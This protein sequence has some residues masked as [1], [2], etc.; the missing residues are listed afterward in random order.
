MLRPYRFCYGNRGR[1]R[2]ASASGEMQK[3]QRR[4]QSPRLRAREDGEKPSP[5][6]DCK[7]ENFRREPL[8]Y[9]LNCCELQFG[10]AMGRPR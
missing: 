7:A 4:P 6:R 8:S 9:A 5:P 3:M 10:A 2:G 1:K